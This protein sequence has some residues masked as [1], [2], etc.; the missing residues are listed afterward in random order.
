MIVVW[1][2]AAA[3][4]A[5]FGAG[6]GAGYLTRSL[7]IAGSAILSLDRRLSGPHSSATTGFPIKK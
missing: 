6:F 2:S 7:S 1:E 4:C 3:L 5:L